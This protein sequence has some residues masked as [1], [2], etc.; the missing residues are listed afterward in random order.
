MASYASYALM[1]PFQSPLQAPAAQETH[2]ITIVTVFEV[3]PA[4]VMTTSETPR[5]VGP[6]WLGHE[7]SL[8]MPLKAHPC[9]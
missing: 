5:R 6:D 1:G 9:Q 2:S 7:R 3:I 8:R 4:A